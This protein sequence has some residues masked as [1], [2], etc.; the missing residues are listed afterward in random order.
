[1]SH[2]LSGYLEVRVAGHGV[3][4]VPQSGGDEV[5][6]HAVHGVVAPPQQEEHNPSEGHHPVQPVQHPPAL[7]G[8]L[9]HHQVPHHQH[10]C[11]PWNKTLNISEIEIPFG[12]R[13]LIKKRKINRKE[14]NNLLAV[15]SA[16]KELVDVKEMIVTS[17]T[18]T[19]EILDE[20]K[21][22]Y[23]RDFYQARAM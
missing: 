18:T 14:T 9:L 1:M 10:T 2:W 16:Q 21:K 19:V 6:T 22:K 17:V 7:G 8:V 3:V 12:K 23:V 20:K 13:I 11:V 5:G 4:D 15:F